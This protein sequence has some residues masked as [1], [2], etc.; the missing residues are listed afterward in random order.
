MKR[1]ISLLLSMLLL[2]GCQAQEEQQ[3]SI[4][5]SA[6]R[7][8][9]TALTEAPTA[10]VSSFS[11][12]DW[13]NGCLGF[14]G[15]SLELSQEEPVYTGGELCLNV[16]CGASRVE[17][18][19]FWYHVNTIKKVEVGI[20]LFLDGQ[21]QPYRTAAVS[22]YRYMQTCT[23]TPL[24]DLS[25]E[26]YLT[27]VT[28]KAGDCLELQV[29]C[30]VWPDYFVDDG[31]AWYQHTAYMVGDTALI[32]FQADPAPAELPPVQ[33]RVVSVSIQQEELRQTGLKDTFEQHSTLFY[34]RDG[35]QLYGITAPT[36]PVLLRYESTGNLT[37]RY[38]LVV[39]VDNQPVSVSQEDLVFFQNEAGKRTV[40][41]LEL[42]LSDF[43]G[44][45]VVYMI[46]VPRNC[47]SGGL[48]AWQDSIEPYYLSGAESFEALVGAE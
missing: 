43:D 3:P 44:E 10:P 37:G 22:E 35:G 34:T 48:P 38:A 29:V 30:L 11:W 20:L 47:L 41:R 15:V 46:A 26:L 16:T 31:P 21:L 2:C 25:L 8:E 6:I 14:K 1:M 24:E 23:P 9:P 28:G 42:D 33:D 19:E 36:E 32:Q 39:F 40:V 18:D 12:D 27:P 17:I 5:L 13:Y 45:S 7:P 4:D